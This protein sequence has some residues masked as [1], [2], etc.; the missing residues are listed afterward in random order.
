MWLPVPGSAGIAN[1]TCTVRLRR[2]LRSAAWRKGVTLSQMDQ[3]GVFVA[4]LREGIQP[5]RM[6]APKYSYR[7]PSVCSSNCSAMSEKHS[8]F[9][10]RGNSS[11]TCAR[12]VRK[13]SM[14]C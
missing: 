6:A 7:Y 14:N 12:S 11:K 13:L 4:E 9:R 2:I 3:L 8:R 1:K 5:L 10:K